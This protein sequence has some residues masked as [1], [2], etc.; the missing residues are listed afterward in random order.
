M[1]H[2]IL[3]EIPASDT[4]GARST[5][6]EIDPMQ[7]NPDIEDEQGQAHKQKAQ[8]NIVRSGAGA[9]FFHHAVTG[10]D[11]KAT[12]IQLS[13]IAESKIRHMQQDVH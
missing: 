9:S 3:P 7:S 2:A 11:T 5:D 13:N 8:S 10:F 1:E 12:A 6:S 4:P